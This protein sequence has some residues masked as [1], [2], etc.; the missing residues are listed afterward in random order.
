M[1][2]EFN[3]PP[4]LAAKLVEVADQLCQGE[5]RTIADFAVGTG[6]LLAAAKQRWPNATF[7]GCDISR[8]RVAS[9]AQVRTDWTLA[10]CN[11]LENSSRHSLS[12]LEKIKAKVD[13]AVL[14]PPFSARGGTRVEVL[15]NGLR[16]RC[17]PAMAFVLIASQYLSPDGSLVTLLPAGASHAERDQDARIA[18][19]Q[20]GEFRAVLE[21]TAKFPGVSLKVT[22]AYLK[23]GPTTQN[24]KTQIEPFLTVTGPTIGLLRGTLQTHNLPSVETGESI[25]LVHS[26]ELQDYRLRE[27]ERQVPFG[28]RSI[29]GPA[30]L[31][32]RVGKPRQDKIAYVPLGPPFA[33]TDCVVVLLCQDEYECLRL[34]NSLTEQFSL[35]ERNYIGS[36]APYIT[37]KRIL[38][39]LQ[40]LGF[41]AEVISWEENSRAAGLSTGGL[42][43]LSFSIERT[44]DSCI[45]ATHK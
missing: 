27:S 3:T 30:V 1:I 19:N 44:E 13:L 10:Q 36:G 9:L 45:E 4:H 5:P 41:A 40:T 32:H 29:T 25:P 11:F 43:G 12:N 26:T 22:I 24:N 2:D 23:R 31:I 8:N 6:E 18:L 20:I 21:E 16:M 7:F 39:V 33:I 38:R 14:N 28:T 37:I 17:S 42:N 35:L 34:H 15:L